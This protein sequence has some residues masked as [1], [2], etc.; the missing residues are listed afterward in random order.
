MLAVCLT[1]C[2]TT[3]TDSLYTPTTEISFVAATA[4]WSRY[5]ALAETFNAHYPNIR[6][7]VLD[8]E[9][10]IPAADPTMTMEARALALLEK[11]D[12]FLSA[13]LDPTIFNA[14]TGVLYD[15]APLLTQDDARALHE[16][17]PGLVER[18]SEDGQIWGIP[19]GVS[20]Y[21]VYYVPAYFDAIQEPY[22]AH[23]WTWPD[24]IEKAQR[25]A[26][27]H[28]NLWGACQIKR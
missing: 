9:T 10:I 27:P 22:P 25:L 21:V 4:N 13:E 11:V 26:A 8:P 12:V 1:A 20:P 5:I 19:L 7:R 18:L 28:N 6:V 16:F 24:F 3:P 23:D 15:L 2:Q 17:Y 14:Q